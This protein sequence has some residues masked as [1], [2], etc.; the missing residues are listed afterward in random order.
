MQ[1]NSYAIKTAFQ[2][3]AF[4]LHPMLLIDHV[5]SGHYVRDETECSTHDSQPRAGGGESM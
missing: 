1:L 4:T 2:R 3:N 5:A